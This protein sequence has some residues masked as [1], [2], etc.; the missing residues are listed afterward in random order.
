MLKT[1]HLGIIFT[2]LLFLY[3]C[4][5]GVYRNINVS[6]A[7]CVELERHDTSAIN[8]LKDIENIPDSNLLKLDGI[9]FTANDSWT[10]S[11]KISLYQLNNSWYLYSYFMKKETTF[12]KKFI[13][14]NTIEIDKVYFDSLKTILD[15]I[16]CDKVDFHENAGI[17]GD[18]FHIGYQ[19]NN[20]LKYFD[21]SYQEDIE[22]I[23]VK[24][25]CE[26]EYIPVPSDTK[27]KLNRVIGYLLKW[28][29]YRKPKIYISTEQNP[30]KDSIRFDI[31]IGRNYRVKTSEIFLNNNKLIGDNLGACRIKTS[32]KEFKKIKSKLTCKVIYQDGEEEWISDSNKVIS[33]NF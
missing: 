30:S 6:N 19:L 15:S 33:K 10:E 26:Y 13:T 32:Q 16:P 29:S 4:K 7:K 5:N 21:F 27:R 11:I 23:I 1:I 20:Q 31:F 25:N 8:R 9:F 12:S 24:L 18:Y 28:S 22:F 2:L 3:A 14:T 17:D